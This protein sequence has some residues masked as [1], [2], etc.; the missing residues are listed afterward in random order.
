M[1]S[2]VCVC[3]VVEIVIVLSWKIFSCAGDR[4]AQKFLRMYNCRSMYKFILVCV[5]PAVIQRYSF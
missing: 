5:F 4:L 3:V 1:T 2:E